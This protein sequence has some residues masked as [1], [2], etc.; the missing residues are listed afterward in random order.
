MI[1]S[2]GSG[3]D[4]KEDKTIIYD[5]NSVYNA[6]F[7]PERKTLKFRAESILFDLVND[8]EYI[9]D[10]RVFDPE[11]TNIEVFRKLEK[12]FVDDGIVNLLYDVF[13][14]SLYDILVSMNLEIEET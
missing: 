2:F 5:L 12:W 9:H 8:P 1:T 7:D 4:G 13:L 6:I 3:Q 14:P 10:P 11:T